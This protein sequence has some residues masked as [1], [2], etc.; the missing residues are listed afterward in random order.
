MPR[1]RSAPA[2]CPTQDA[3]PSLLPRHPRTASAPP[4]GRM[5][6]H[7][8]RHRRRCKRPDHL[9]SANSSPKRSSKIISFRLDSPRIRSLHTSARR[10][11]A[12]ETLH[13]GPRSD[14][15]E[16]IETYRLTGDSAHG[17][18]QLLVPPP[19]IFIT[20]KTKTKIHSPFSSKFSHF[21]FCFVQEKRKR[22][23]RC[24]TNFSFFPP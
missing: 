21:I 17:R 7:A 4:A 20:K 24:D 10:E 16:H 19:T 2:V 9:K 1:M 18:E 6:L 5:R 14:T 11:F 12:T 13:P 3:H 23:H 8:P 15:V 22:A